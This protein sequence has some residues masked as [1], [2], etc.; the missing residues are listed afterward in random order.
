MNIEIPL[1]EVVKQ[2]VKELGVVYKYSPDEY[3]TGLELANRLNLNH[4]SYKSTIARW[5]D[6]RK[7]NPPLVYYKTGKEHSYKWDDV[8]NFIDTHLRVD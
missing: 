3:I 5:K 6:P 8:T 4:K 7:H 1:E 2:V